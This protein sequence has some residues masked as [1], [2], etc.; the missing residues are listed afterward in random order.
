M[1]GNS[2]GIQIETRA[3]QPWQQEQDFREN[4]YE[5]MNATPWVMISLAAH[6]LLFFIA[7]TIPWQDLKQVEGPI[8]QTH[9]PEPIEEIFDT[10]EPPPEFVEVEKPEEPT[11]SDSTLPEDVVPVPDSPD[12]T[13]ELVSDFPFDEAA[14]LKK[15]GLGGSA[16]SGGGKGEGRN[17][18]FDQAGTTTE[19]AL[20]SALAWLEFHQ[21]DDGSWDADGFDAE[22]GA[23][24]T[25]ICA[26]TGYPE[27]DVGV[28]GLALLAFLGVGS[29]SK[30]GPYQDL[31]RNGLGYLKSQQDPESG[32]IGGRTSKE[33]IYNHVIATLALCED[34]YFTKNPSRKRV[35]QRAID[36]ITQARDPYPPVSG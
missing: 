24:G 17:Q 1:S 22:C 30:S 14:N 27:H 8:I 35:A 36:F 15:L 5:W 18:G 3:A 34:Y 10:P 26:G 20:K 23:L 4:L 29:H 21:A 19:Q 9:K 7:A 25:N 2:I 33:F 32:L 31:V 11:P 12:S 16:G 13:H 28:T 6:L